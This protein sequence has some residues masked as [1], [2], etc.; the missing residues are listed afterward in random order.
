MPE[1]SSASSPEEYFARVEELEAAKAEALGQ[2]PLPALECESILGSGEAA[3]QLLHVEAGERLLI[4]FWEPTC[5]MCGPVLEA[6]SDNHAPGAL[7]ARTLGVVQVPGPA[8]GEGGAWGMEEV[9]R[10]MTEHAV[11][12]PVCVHSSESQTRAWQ[13]EGVPLTLLLN[14]RG[15]VERLALGARNSLA[16]LA[17]LRTD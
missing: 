2:S 8:S 15:E 12:F 17:E 6:L 3:G 9:R 16:L 13:A 4:S 5:P 1:Q 14:D 11:T 10:S 7:N